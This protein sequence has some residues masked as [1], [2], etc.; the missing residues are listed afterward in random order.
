MLVSTTN[1]RKDC[2]QIRGRPFHHDDSLNDRTPG[3]TLDVSFRETCRLWEHHYQEPYVVEGGM[4]RGEPSQAWFQHAV[5]GAAGH[6]ED[7]TTQMQ[8]VLLA[9]SFSAGLEISTTARILWKNLGE[10]GVYLPAA[11]R[12]RKRGENS[13]PNRE[14]Y[15]FG[16]GSLGVG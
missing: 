7:D 11:P 9:G 1:Y 4:Y 15:V 16:K 3:A 13:N 8:R 12:S 10:P 5:A 2:V 6:G 14:N